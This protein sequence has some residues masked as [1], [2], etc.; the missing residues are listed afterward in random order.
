MFKKILWIIGILI[1]ILSLMG[2][3]Y[4]LAKSNGLFSTG[5]SVSKCQDTPCCK[6]SGYDYFDA[7]LNSCYSAGDLDSS[8]SGGGASG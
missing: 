2:L 5:D 8:S 1:L 4:Y 6:N 7:Q 3:S